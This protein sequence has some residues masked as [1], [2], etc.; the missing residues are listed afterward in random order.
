V[1]QSRRVRQPRPSGRSPCRHQSDA[2][3]RDAPCRARARRA[4]TPRRTGGD[5]THPSDCT[6][7]QR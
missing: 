5:A 4:G 6:R 7:F 3:T 1:D 2:V